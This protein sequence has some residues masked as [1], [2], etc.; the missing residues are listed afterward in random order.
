MTNIFDI[1][2]IVFLIFKTF[3]CYENIIFLSRVNKR[4]HRISTI[5]PIIIDNFTPTLLG[6]DKKH[7]KWW[8]ENTYTTYVNN[9][10]HGP[11]E[12][13]SIWDAD[14]WYLYATGTFQNGKQHGKLRRYQPDGMLD[15]T[16]I[17]D[18]DKCLGC[19]FHSIEPGSDVYT[20]FNDGKSI[21]KEYINGVIVKNVHFWAGSTTVVDYFENGN[22]KKTRTYNN[23]I[24]QGPL[25]LYY[26]DGSIR[27][28]KYYVDNI[29]VY[30]QKFRK[31]F[32]W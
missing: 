29:P 3:D 16:Q 31:G 22:I 10:K 17:Y 25:R 27:R 18:N 1:N 9:I 30:S 21:R 12:V 20:S 26:R 11:Y 5:I 6:T 19:I 24:L 23:D 4:C 13:W 14:D 2:E 32:I 15:L 7:G 8:A 28:E